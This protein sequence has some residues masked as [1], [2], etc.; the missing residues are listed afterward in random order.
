MAVIPK[1]L[2][3]PVGESLLPF[4]SDFIWY[5]CD[6]LCLSSVANPPLEVG[7]L[8]HN[9]NKLGCFTSL[10]ALSSFDLPSFTN[11]P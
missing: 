9:L 1:E 7:Y 3:Q 5:L 11:F 8:H 10:V 2:L 4:T 6:F